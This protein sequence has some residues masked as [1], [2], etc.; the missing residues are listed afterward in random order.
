MAGRTRRLKPIKAVAMVKISLAIPLESDTQL[1]LYCIKNRCLKQDA[2]AKAIRLLAG[3][4]YLAERLQS[5]SAPLIEP[6]PAPLALHA[7]G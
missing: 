3:G 1:E 2:L 7:V 4:L 5:G 6:E